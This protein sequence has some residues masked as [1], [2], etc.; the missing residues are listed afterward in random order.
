MMIVVQLAISRA[1]MRML[2]NAPPLNAGDFGADSRAN[3]LSFETEDGLTLQACHFPQLDRSSR[4][5]ILFCH[6]LG[7]SR[8]SAMSYCEA[9]FAAGFEV[10]SFDFRNH[11]SS[12]KQTGYEPLHWLTEFE[13]ADVRGALQLIESRNELKSQPLGIFGVSRGGGAALAAASITGAVECVACESA[14]ST[15]SM[16]SLF[17]Q[18]WVS[19]LVPQWM[20]GWIP[21][22]HV[23]L[24]L[25]GGRLYSQFKRKCRYVHLERTLAS[26]KNRPVLLIS[27]ERDNYVRPEIANALH[28]CLGEET[29]ELWMV[30]KARHNGARQADKEGYD[31]RLIE[32]FSALSSESREEPAT[33]SVE[34]SESLR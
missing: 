13:L 23:E 19:L 4:G 32:F 30:P 33:D 22:W 12:E 31:Q 2:E 18:R 27:G 7:G 9:L 5:L 6:E 28:E 3:E 24:S 21:A 17:S 29:A 15:R 26:L 34:V 1:V 8:W 10:L 20:A 25:T 14:Y 16:M 11:G